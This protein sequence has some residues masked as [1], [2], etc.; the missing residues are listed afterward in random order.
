MQHQ[1]LGAQGQRSFNFSTERFNGFLQKDL[2]RRSKVDEVIR[3]DDQGLQIIFIPQPRHFI[4]LWSA[5]LI[6][7]PLPRTRRENLKR[8]AAEP[9]RALRRV[10]HASGNRGVNSDPVRG[11]PWR[12]LGRGQ[13]ENILAPERPVAQIRMKSILYNHPLVFQ[14]I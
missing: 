1:I 5:Q 7:R 11:Q 6:R 13:L 3:V 9:V 2:V 8:I 4:A 12:S 10:L 14:L